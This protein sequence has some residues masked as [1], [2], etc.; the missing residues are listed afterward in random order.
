ERL[1]ASPLNTRECG[2]DRRRVGCMWGP[3]QER[4]A[5]GPR[6]QVAPPEP[7]ALVVGRCDSARQAPHH[8]PE[9]HTPVG[10]ATARTARRHAESAEYCLMHTLAGAGSSRGPQGRAPAARAATG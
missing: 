7:N 3:W 4:T 6:P 8:P 5:G 9:W 2:I 1:R 10:I